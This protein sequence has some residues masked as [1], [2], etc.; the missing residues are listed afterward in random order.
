MDGQDV[1]EIKEF[2]YLGATICKER[3]GMKNLKNRL[4]KA[5]G[6]FARLKRI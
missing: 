6:T 5:R 1:S 2:N 4:F 3:G